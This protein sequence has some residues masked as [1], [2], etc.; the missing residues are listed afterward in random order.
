MRAVPV[1]DVLLPSQ[2]RIDPDQFYE[3]VC[4]ARA[5]SF[6]IT[7]SLIDGRASVR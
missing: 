4:L 6:C 7:R 2:H 1:E 5:D 3:D